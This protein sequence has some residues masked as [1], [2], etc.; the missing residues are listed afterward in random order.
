[1]TISEILNKVKNEVIETYPTNGISIIIPAESN[2]T[3]QLTNTNNEL[4]TL[5]GSL[6]NDNAMSMVNLKGCES[7]LKESNNIPKEDPLIILK[8]E[9]STNFAFEKNVQYEIY[10]PITFDKLNLDICNKNDIDIVI[11]MELNEDI[12]K[13][14]DSLKEEGYNLFNEKDKFYSDIC[15][16]YTAQNGADVLLDD[17]FLYFYNKVINITT[18]PK[19]CK[20]SKFFFDTKTLSCQCKANNE[21]IDIENMDKLNGDLGYT[22]SLN[23]LKYSSYKTMKCYKL[24]FNFNHFIK[25]AGS[26]IIL[27]FLIAYIGFMI[28]YLMKGISP[29]KLSIYKNFFEEK[30]HNEEYDNISKID[31]LKSFAGNEKGKTNKKKKLENRSVKQSSKK[32]FPKIEVKESKKDLLYPPKKSRVDKN[33]I[34]S[35]EKQK[36]TENIKLIDIIKNKKKHMIN[37]YKSNNNDN[38]GKIKIQKFSNIRIDKLG[39]GPRINYNFQL[40]RD[41]EPDFD[42]ESLKS[43]KV[44]KRK[45]I[46]D[47]AREREIRKKKEKEKEK[48]LIELRDNK[49]SRKKNEEPD[50]ETNTEARMTPRKKGNENEDNALDD[51]ELNH[52][53]YEE[54]LE[55]DKRSFCKIYW[56][57]IKRDELFIFT[58]LSW[59]DYNLFYVKIERFF[60]I[61]LNIMAMNAFL[62]PDKSIHLYFLNGVKFDF[63]QHI[64]QIVLSIIIT[65]VIEIL[66]CYLSLTDRSIYQIKG[67]AKHEEN[68]EKIFEIM[69]K[70]KIKLLI[71]FFS[72]FLVSIFYWYFIS[73]FCAVYKNTQK[74]FIIVCVISL[75]IFLIDPFIVYALVTLVRFLSI[76]R[77]NN[78][79]VKC[80]YTISRIFPIF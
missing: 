48:I 47:Y 45:S 46:I 29:L 59:N 19:D 11:P 49:L 21:N 18:C 73:A 75:L 37:N 2:Y 1:M 40:R 50:K 20:Y 78:K 32:G 35:N 17:R 3:L 22:P 77:I 80:L 63:T 69:N 54:A 42:I 41:K 14:Y 55:K 15:S 62:F 68:K 58:F 56:S 8:Y 52:L 79:K 71:F 38:D 44:R 24:V 26:I 34:N 36:E 61:I 43:D 39:G 60:F 6:L 27:V 76:K 65:H 7:L 23:G 53:E 74:I 64:L 28:Y 72:I 30:K 13:L 9:K 67:L 33:E 31:P 10:N 70:M 16:P 51:Y 4:L 66:L 25:N 12:E 57:I 5:N